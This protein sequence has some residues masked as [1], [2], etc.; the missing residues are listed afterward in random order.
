MNSMFNGCKLLNEIN[1][2]NINTQNVTDMNCFFYGCESLKNLD[3]SK[4]NTEKVTSMI[5]MFYECKS[6]KN[7]D[8]S[9]FNTE[10]V[11]YMNGLFFGCE[12]LNEINVT[13]FNTENVINMGK[14]F[15]GCKSLNYLDLSKFNTRKV[16]DMNSMFS[17]CTLLKDINVINFNPTRDV[18]CINM[19]SDC[20][21]FPYGCIIL[22]NLINAKNNKIDNNDINNI[23]SK[24]KSKQNIIEY[25]NKIN[26]KFIKE[27]NLK[28]KL[29]TN[30]GNKFTIFEIFT[31]YIDNTDY[32]AFSDDSDNKNLKIF[33]FYENK[34]KKKVSVKFS[35]KEIR[36]FIN[37]NNYNE[38]LLI[39]LDFGVNILYITNNYINIFENY[40]HEFDD[41][42]LVFPNKNDIY[43]VHSYRFYGTTGYYSDEIEHYHYAYTWAELLF[44]YKSCLYCKKEED[45]VYLL[46]SWY[47]KKNNLYYIL[48]LPRFRNYINIYELKSEKKTYTLGC[49]NSINDG[50]ITQNVSESN[51]TDYLI[52]LT[53]YKIYIYNLENGN[54]VKTCAIF[55]RISNILNT[56]AVFGGCKRIGR[57]SQWKERYI[58][59]INNNHLLEILD[60][61][62]YK[63]ITVI[64]STDD[65]FNIKKINHQ[66]YGESLLISGKDSNGIQLWTI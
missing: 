14:M 51:Q 17:G 24:L 33:Y 22:S 19:F 45:E 59:F 53:D 9:N 18:D 65:L 2:S 25:N 28:Y 48:Q 64:K 63:I 16:I 15:Y 20:D 8:V 61:K 46:L 35:I 54:L 34:L 31:S 52:V 44:T 21:S 41:C 37:K 29:K 49:P 50:F 36:Y 27:P 62:I 26:Y 1:L 38:Y 11:I 23:I 56:I 43:F 60:L 39:I 4:L 42:L 66:I 30:Y 32:I 13:N 40:H 10:K 57:F 58:I 6:L 47:N 12:L 55:N 3:V 5:G 7:I